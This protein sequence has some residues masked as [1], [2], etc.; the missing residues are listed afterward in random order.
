LLKTKGIKIPGKSGVK[1]EGTTS[2]KSDG[3]IKMP[4][5]KKV[6]LQRRSKV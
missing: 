4:K 6:T 2:E 3:A 1:V 5:G